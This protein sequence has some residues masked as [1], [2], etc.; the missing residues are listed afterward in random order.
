[1]TTNRRS[2]G[3][4]MAGLALAL[5]AGCSTPPP[6]RPIFADLRY[7]AE[8]PIRLEVGRI[9]IRDEYQAPFKA[10]NVDHLFPVPPARAAENWAHDRLKATGKT[11]RAVFVLK[12]ASVIETELPRSQ[13]LTGA[14]TTEPAQRYDLALQATVEIV[15]DRGLPIRT[16]NVSTT[17]SQSVL[18]D[19]S[20]NQ[21]D[22]AWYDM[23][24]AAM[25]DFD[26]QLASEIRNN[27]G[28][29]YDQ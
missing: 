19:I 9:E 13:G 20:P 23:T 4:A 2:R 16:A 10:P 6:P 17:R 1:M 8:P 29:Y 22:H 14:L 25:T 3:L 15:D 7:T 28:I 26:Q 5:L 24:K 21:R 18:D 11:G 27:F 12:N